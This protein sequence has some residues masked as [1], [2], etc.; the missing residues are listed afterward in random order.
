[1]LLTVVALLVVTNLVTGLTVFFLAQPAPTPVVLCA[2]SE[3]A[4]SAPPRSSGLAPS[5]SPE[6]ATFRYTL[7]TGPPGTQQPADI[8]VIGPWAGAEFDAF[9]PVLENFTIA[10]GI[11]WEYEQLR[12]E[13]LVTILP[14]QFDA[15]QA[16]GDVIF[17]VSSFIKANGAQHMIEESSNLS[18]SDFVPGSLDPVKV[19]DNIYGGVYTGKAKPGFWYR[20]SFF[21]EHNL[22]VPTTFTE[23]RNLLVTISGIEGIRTPIVSGDGVGWPLS[24]LTEHFIASYGGASMHRDLLSGTKDWT[25]ADVRAIFADRLVPLLAGGCFSEPL[26]WNT[27]ALTNWWGGLHGL[28]FMGSWITGLVADPDDLGVFALPIDAGTTRGMVFGG[29]YYFIPKYTA[30]QADAQALFDYLAS[31][32]GQTI[33]VQQGGH[34]ATAMGVPLSE[35]PLVDR[36]VAQL[37]TDVEI[38]S[39]LD[40]FIGGDFQ[41]T[42]WNQLQLLW[43]SPDQLDSVLARIQ[44]EMTA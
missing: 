12:Q 4:A 31:A 34:V 15:E 42:F 30:N 28:Y 35:Y 2:G 3:G 37:M 13:Q 36:G 19:G 32:E 26:E 24:D 1:M 14:T 25:D 7:G 10:T 23:F 22:T 40:D 39:D 16:P 29:D 5:G 38:L 9:L 11:T 17:M 44:A 20:K 21:Q 43:V 41:Q 18:D 8:T 27:V 33:Q 6:A